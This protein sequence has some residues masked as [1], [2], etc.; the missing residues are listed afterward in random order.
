[1]VTDVTAVH[2]R[3]APPTLVAV[4]F[5]LLHARALARPAAPPRAGVDGRAADVRARRRRPL[6]R[7]RGRAGTGRRSGSSTCSAPSSTCRASPSARSTC[8]AGQRAGDRSRS[9]SRCWRRSPPGSWPW[10]RSTAPIVGHRRCPRAATSSAPLPRILAAVG[11]GGAALVIIGGAMLSLVAGA[12]RTRAPPGRGVAP[13]P[14]RLAVGNVLIARG[15]ARASAQRHCSTAGSATIDGVRRHARRSASRS[16]S[17]A[18]WSRPSPRL[19]A[20]APTATGR[21]R[22][23]SAARAAAPCRPALGQLVDEQHLR[24]ALVAGEARGGSAR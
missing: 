21:G 12:G 2:A 23:V 1:M 24:R 9:G 17:P 20:P 22:L 5:A 6:G 3:G 15:H 13:H 11:S 16:C 7:R 10:R 14:E 19:G 18:S 8:S 4:A